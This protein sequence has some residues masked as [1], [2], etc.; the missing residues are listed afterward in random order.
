MGERKRKRRKKKEVG[1]QEGRLYYGYCYQGPTFL[2]S[3]RGMWEGE[4]RQLKPVEVGPVPHP[5]RQWRQLY[6]L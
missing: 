2:G 1:E 5:H 4:K 6:P 3:P